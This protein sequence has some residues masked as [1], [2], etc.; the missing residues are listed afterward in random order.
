MPIILLIRHGENDYVKERRLPGRKSGIH[1]N[2]RGRKQAKALAKRLENAP[3]KAVYSSPL[4]R[5][6]ETAEPIA[7][8]LGLEVIPR[9]GLIETDVGDW[10]GKKLKRLSKM[11]SWRKVQFNP[12]RFR[13]PGGER[14]LDSQQRFVAEV[15]KLSAKHEAMDMIICVSHADPIKLVTAHYLGLPLDFFQRLTVAPAS[16]TALQIGELGSRLLFLN[17]VPSFNFAKH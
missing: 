8:A 11:E 16:I 14:F 10:Q 12:S 9:A 6:M 1:L 4:E 13:F 17:Y 3:V 15:E 7:E 5:T 2:K